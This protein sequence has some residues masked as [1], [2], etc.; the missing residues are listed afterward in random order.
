MLIA[1]TFS[2]F[3]MTG[4][5]TSNQLAFVVQSFTYGKTP[6]EI[7]YSASA[8]IAGF[9]AG[10]FIYPPLFLTFGRSAVL[11]WG[12]IVQLITQIWAAKMTHE[13]QYVGMIISRLFSGLVAVIPIAS[14]NSYIME[15]YFLHQRGRLFALFELV[16][17]FGV[18]AI[19]TIGGFVLNNM[20]LGWSW[21]FWWTCPV[22]GL[23]AV[24]VFLFVHETDFNRETGQ[25]TQPEHQSFIRNRITTFLLGWRVV[26]RTNMA[27][28]VSDL[29]PR[30]NDKILTL[31]SQVKRTFSS[32]AIAVLPVTIGK[33]TN[34]ITPRY[35]KTNRDFRTRIL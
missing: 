35:I 32:L 7:S 22:L 30:P 23:A 3:A 28:V 8:A 27:N 16:F 2:A 20:S 25:T 18:T 31:V 26:P 19:P 24:L 33:I 29:S 4:S 9:I 12:I 34:D 10:P 14:G 11:F 15:A 21:T 13:S 1:L 17:L 6:V 5:P